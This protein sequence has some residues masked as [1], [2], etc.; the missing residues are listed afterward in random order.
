MAGFA[1]NTMKGLKE[2]YDKSV[3]VWR[4]SKKPDRSDLN[5]KVKVVLLG[6][7]VL[8]FLGFLI[9]IIFGLLP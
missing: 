7:F 5:E 2:F 6:M 4:L 1:S 9:S 3:Y 8:G